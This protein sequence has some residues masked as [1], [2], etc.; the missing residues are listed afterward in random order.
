MRIVKNKNNNNIFIR[1]FVLLGDPAQDIAFPVQQV[2]TTMINGQR[3]DSVQD[4]LLG[5]SRVTVRGEV[6][7]VQG[8][9]IIRHELKT[10]VCEGEYQRGIYRI[11]DTFLKHIDEPKQPAV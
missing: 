6:R 11:L 1:N 2:V 9:K 4:T 10:F 5:M 8:L 3:A 7:D